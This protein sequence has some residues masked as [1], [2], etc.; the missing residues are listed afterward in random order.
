M[1]KLLH[2]SSVYVAATIL[3]PSLNLAWFKDHWHQYKD[4]IATTEQS[5]K[6]FYSRMTSEQEEEE[7]I[8]T[9]KKARDDPEASS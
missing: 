2:K 3:H 4:W 7:P 8:A 9:S 6:D 5:F 1:D